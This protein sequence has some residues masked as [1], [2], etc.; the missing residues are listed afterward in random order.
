MAHTINTIRVADNTIT[1]GDK[2]KVINGSGEDEE[3][4][5]GVEKR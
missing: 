2:K 5:Q 1:A 3:K 4:V